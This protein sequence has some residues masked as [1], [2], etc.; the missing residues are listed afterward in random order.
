MAGGDDGVGPKLAVLRTWYDGTVADALE[1]CWRK[2]V[3][4]VSMSIGVYD[5]EECV[6]AQ[7]DSAYAH[8][9]V[10]VAAAGNNQQ[11]NAVAFPAS[12][13]KVIAVGATDMNDEW[14]SYSS[15]GPTL[16]IT[17]P[18]GISTGPEPQIFTTDNYQVGWDFN[19]TFCACPA[20]N[21]RYFSKFSGTSAS[22]PQVAGVAALL[23]SHK[24]SLGNSGVR[25]LLVRTAV[26]IGD[27]GWDELTGYGRL[28]ALAAIT[29]ADQIVQGPIMTNTTWSGTLW[30]A[31][32]VTVSSGVVLTVDPGTTIL[33]D[34]NDGQASG[35]YPDKIEFNI[36][37]SIDVNGTANSPVTFRS[38]DGQAGDW[39][40]FYL[41]A[42]SGGGSFDH[43]QIKD[44]EYGVETYVGIQ[45]NNATFTSCA[46]AGIV[47]Q[48]GSSQVTSTTI[49]DCGAWGVYN[50]APE[51]DTLRAS[52]CF[53]DGAAAAAFHVQNGSISL[54]D[55]VTGR[56]GVKGVYI[57][58]LASVS[59]SNSTFSANDI[60][61]HC[62]GATETTFISSHADSNANEGML[63]DNNSD[64]VVTGSSFDSNESG[65][66][67]LNYSD[68]YI[69]ESLLNVNYR[70]MW[71][72][73]GSE[74]DAGTVSE[75]GENSVVGTT[76]RYAVVNFTEDYTFQAV[77]NWWGEYPP[78][79]NRFLNAVDYMPALTEPPGSM[80]SVGLPPGDP[81][82]S[83]PNGFL[84][85]MPNPFNPAITVVYGVRTPAHAS[86]AIYNV[87][88]QVVTVL[89]DAG[90]PAGRHVV[91]WDGSDRKGQPVASG[92]Y[93]AR[94]TV[95]SLIQTRKLVLLR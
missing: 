42:T 1:Y 34:K 60:G 12:H 59:I 73:S 32:D 87:R 83:V 35:F 53:V 19:P 33:I 50:T 10:L 36:E 94:L 75:H 63:C 7:L 54:L 26:D 46:Y 56:N 6:A 88:G 30:V 31:G 23:L 4:V 29:M 91:T 64:L 85:T 79:A 57:A 78:P 80:M 51:T 72:A 67:A 86:L 61:V 84:G 92:V 39:I 77:G 16:E 65:I 9:V 66:V 69:R 89:F 13:P 95:G 71:C 49:T 24:P 44:A 40:G 55:G 5:Q 21:D 38:F 48:D 8:G 18:S 28:D 58:P 17:A 20:A 52:S 76:G 2:G 62:Y 27:P 14:L 43:V 25:L 90:K 45:V 37:G 22:A 70:G 3:D 11:L 41:D 74:P 68:P 15:L 82:A 47:A 81:P 93:F